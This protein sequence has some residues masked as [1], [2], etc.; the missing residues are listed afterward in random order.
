MQHQDDYIPSYVLAVVVAVIVQKV[1][2]E[3]GGMTCR[4]ES[5]PEPLQHFAVRFAHS[6]TRVK[7]TEFVLS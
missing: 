4:E 2:T 5:N 1:G 3:P 6:T 7:T